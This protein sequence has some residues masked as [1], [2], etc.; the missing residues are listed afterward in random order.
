MTNETMT[1]Q[2]LGFYRGHLD[3]MQHQ[4]PEEKMG[5]LDPG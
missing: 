5:I 3:Q 4:A 1:H 2:F